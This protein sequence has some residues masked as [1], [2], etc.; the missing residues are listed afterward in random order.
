M[1]DATKHVTVVLDVV[2]GKGG[3]GGGAGAI[4]G[5]ILAGNKANKSNKPSS[6]GEVFKDLITPGNKNGLLAGILGGSVGGIVGQAGGMAGEALGG[7]LGALIGKQVGNI[8]GD[9]LD[10]LMHPIQTF[11]E[12]ASEIAGY[13][14]A[15]NPQAVERFNMA[16]K[17]LT[18]VFGHALTPAME[19]FT[20]VVR[21]I[22]DG[23]ASSDLMAAWRSASNELKTTLENLAPLIRGA[24]RALGELAGVAARIATSKSTSGAA[25]LLMGLIPGTGLLSELLGGG[26]GASVG[27]AA[28]QANFSGV[29]EFGRQAA[30]ATA[31][32]GQSSQDPQAKIADNTDMMVR[33]LERIAGKETAE[34]ALGFRRGLLGF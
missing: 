4:V 10:K 7:P 32:S 23:L 31:S 14:Q 29:E 22:A 5:N 25:G 17:D 18:A 27:L 20:D 6:I 30:L 15:A 16:T 13:V 9:I 2:Q 26:A 19:T 12:V 8:V 21:A 28:H 1:A 11:K 24:S 33:L 3:A 34:A